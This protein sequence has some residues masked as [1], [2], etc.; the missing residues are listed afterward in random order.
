MSKHQYVITL[1]EAQHKELETIFLRYS[2][3]RDHWVISSDL[4]LA[5]TEAEKIKVGCGCVGFEHRE[6][7]PKWV[8]PY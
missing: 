5:V 6:S 4:K 7:C 3:Q 1:T 2:T 8:L